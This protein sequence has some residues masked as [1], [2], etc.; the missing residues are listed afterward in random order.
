[1]RP[2]PRRS[3]PD[4]CTRQGHDENH[5]SRQQGGSARPRTRYECR[6]NSQISKK[7]FVFIDQRTV[8]NHGTNG[9]RTGAIL[10]TLCQYQP[11]PTVTDVYMPKTHRPDSDRPCMCLFLFR[12]EGCLHRGTDTWIYSGPTTT[13]FRLCLLRHRGI[14]RGS[15]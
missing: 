3:S 14:H 10:L 2:F 6:S 8:S 5:F 7:Y 9:R 13:P 12:S 1:M 11:L 15:L 4:S